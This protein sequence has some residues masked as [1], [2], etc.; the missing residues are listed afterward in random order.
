LKDGG[1]FVWQ[2]DFHKAI[3]VTKN[4]AAVDA[5][6]ESTGHSHTFI[7][8]ADYFN[9]L[10]GLDLSF[11]VVLN[12]SMGRS[13]LYTGF[14]D[15]GGSVDIGVKGTYLSVWE[16]SLNYRNYF[17]TTES[18][19]IGSAPVNVGGSAANPA[20]WAQTLWDRDFI[21]FNIGRTF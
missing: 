7:L 2:Y 3:E 12:Y 10:D 18:T 21:S 14:V 15:G 8:T 9:A 6:S 19:S 17:G 5:A 16:M 4:D 13:R 1:S 20:D 11:P